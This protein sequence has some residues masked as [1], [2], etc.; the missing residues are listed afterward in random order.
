MLTFSRTLEKESHYQ[1]LDGSHTNHHQDFH[2]TEIEYPLFRTLDCTEV[3]VFSCSE[4]L[5]HSADRA[6]LTTDL[7]DSILKLSSLSV[8]GTTFC[9]N[10]G[11]FLFIFNLCRYG[12]LAGVHHLSHNAEH[13]SATYSYLKVYHFVG[14]CRHLIAEA[15]LVFTSLLC[16]EYIVTL[17][18]LLTV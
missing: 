3:S 16:S 13:L 4:I 15:E 5:L 1:D 7:E 10:R 12:V 6:Q 2:Q 17:P 9:R 8:V 14:K 18:L 11:M